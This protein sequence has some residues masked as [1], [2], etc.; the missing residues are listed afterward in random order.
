MGPIA[1]LLFLAKMFHLFAALMV[2]LSAGAAVLGLL[3]TF[4]RRKAFF[5]V[6][7]ATVLFFIFL[8]F[9]NAGTPPEERA[10]LAAEAQAAAQVRQKQKTREAEEQPERI[11]ATQEVKPAQ[12]DKAALLGLAMS[13]QLQQQGSDV[14]VMGLDD[15]L[16]FDCTKAL[17]PRV[18]CYFLYKNYPPNNN[19]QKILT[20]MGVRTLEFKTNPGLFSRYAWTKHI[21]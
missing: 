3:A 7:S 17:D 21:P 15:E 5:V 9:F 18:A 8:Y 2:P 4:F 11:K 16:I 1:V 20:M 19:E 13:R 14:T 10:R 6:L 12:P